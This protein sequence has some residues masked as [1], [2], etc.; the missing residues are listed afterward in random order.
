MGR[1]EEEQEGKRVGLTFYIPVVDYSHDGTNTDTL[2]WRLL[3]AVGLASIKQIKK[4][5]ALSCSLFH[6]YPPVSLFDSIVEGF[7]FHF[8]HSF[9]F[10]SVSN[11]YQENDLVEKSS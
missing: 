4:V 2:G 3:V 1:S 5:L 8:P 10:G 6:L 7:T 9:Y 11:N